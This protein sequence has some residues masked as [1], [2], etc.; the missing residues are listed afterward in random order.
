MVSVTLLNIY[1][2]F[3]NVVALNNVS[4]SA[5]DGKIT[6][7]LGPSGCGKTTT[8]R[9]IAGFI[10]PDSGIVKFDNVTVN[11][12]PPQ[13]RNIGFVFQNIALFP[14]L[15]VFQNIAFGLELRKYPKDK[16]KERV[17]ELLELLSLKG[18]ENRYPRELSGGQQQRVGLAR[19]LAPYPQVLLL[20]EPLSS[21][22]ANLREQLKWE[23]RAIQRKTG[24][25]AIYVTHDLSEAFTIGDYILIMNNGR[26]IQSGTPQEILYHPAN[27]FVAE[28]LR[29]SNFFEGTV[30]NVKGTYELVRTKNGNMFRLPKEH[31]VG[32]Q[33]LFSVRPEDFDILLNFKQNSLPP[34]G[35]YLQGKITRAYFEGHYFKLKVSTSEGP[36]TVIT[37]SMKLKNNTTL[38]KDV[39]LE[40][41]PDVV[42][43]ISPS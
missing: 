12:I 3:G 8:L 5:P 19:A 2:Q 27:R 1:K 25:T 36:I 30:I 41:S 20:D 31:N 37:T 18:L 29:F 42:V 35:N 39:I 26:I 6:V 17:Y 14:H 11:D 28:F 32:D 34:E 40:F 7:L 10:Q 22:D 23:I 33:V 13:K 15:T 21:L 43:F 16:I 38:S 9:I 24:V 4:F